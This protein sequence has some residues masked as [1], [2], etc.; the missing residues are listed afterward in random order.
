MN[1]PAILLPV[2]ALAAWTLL[3]LLFVFGV[4]VNAGFKRKIVASDFKVGESASVPAEVSLPNRNYINLLELPVLFYVVCLV[5]FTTNT[6][7]PLA[8]LLAWIFVALRIIHSLVHITYN[9]VFH[10]LSVFAASY[11]VLVVLW[12]LVGLQLPA[13]VAAY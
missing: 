4:R 9:N 3:I 5:L 13:L 12:I 7:S 11:V 10:R 1:N 8:I 2:V 6:S